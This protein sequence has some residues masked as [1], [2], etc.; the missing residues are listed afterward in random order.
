MKMVKARKMFH[1]IQDLQTGTIIISNNQIIKNT[2]NMI[3]LPIYIF[4]HY[5]RKWIMRKL[6]KQT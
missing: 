1:K 2:K 3:D 6:S 5:K 4:K